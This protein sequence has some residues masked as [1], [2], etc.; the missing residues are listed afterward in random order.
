MW[1]LIWLKY[2][3]EG[4]TLDFL[5]RTS[6]VVFEE[7]GGL[8]TIMIIHE[9]VA[10]DKSAG[11]CNF[12]VEIGIMH[13]CMSESPLGHFAG[14]NRSSDLSKDAQT[15]MEI[16][17]RMRCISQVCVR[18]ASA[19][20]GFLGLSLLFVHIFKDTL[21]TIQHFWLIAQQGSPCRCYFC[22]TNLSFI[23][24]MHSTKDGG[25]NVFFATGC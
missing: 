19:V 11:Y 25:V 18:S 15:C 3:N 16:H 5:W 7:N 21:H 9:Y 17:Y 14:K 1:S 22:Q 12:I 23:F 8:C 2:L 20:N 10:T 6:L 13:L 24:L 4:H